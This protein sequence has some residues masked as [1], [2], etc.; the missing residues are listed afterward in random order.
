MPAR[1]VRPY[2]DAAVEC[3]LGQSFTDFELVIR[4]DGS[5]DGTCE[6]LRHWARQDKRIRLFEGDQLG[7]SGSS[8]WIVQQARAPLI[9]RMDG[10]DIACPE[11]L[12]R[13][14]EVLSRH[15]DVLLIGSLADSIDARGRRIRDMDLWRI[16]RRSWFP[17][18]PHTSV[19]FRRDAF[20]AAGG[21][22][23]WSYCEDWDFFLRLAGQ[24][25][26]AVIADALV[27]H[28]VIVTSSS[29]APEGRLVVQNAVD[30]VLLTLPSQGSAESYQSPQPGGGEDASQRVHPLAI[31]SSNSTCLWSGGSPRVLGDL[32]RRGRLRFDVA[33]FGALGWAVLAQLSPHLLR[34]ALRTLLLGRN[35]AARTKVRRGR[36]YRW[37]PGTG[38]SRPG[39]IA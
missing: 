36:V 33:S 4:D 27:S 13:Q 19:M 18:F 12:E 3:I 24:G 11:R 39:E 30:R 22:H 8:N 2:I 34:L 5:V 1:N 38:R 17:P 29:G 25:Q 32:L 6:R 10:D 37:Q 15:P 16:C 28:R 20:E 31:I 23:P 7:L 26:V 9:A 21:Y 14:F 35:L